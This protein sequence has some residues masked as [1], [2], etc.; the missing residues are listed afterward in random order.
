[1]INITGKYTEANIMIDQV[2]SGVIRQVQNLCNHPLFEDKQI[3]VMPD[4]HV[5]KSTVVGL[6]CY[7]E[8]ETL[9][10]SLLGSDIG[11]GML[12]IKLKKCATLNDYAKLDKVIR[13]HIPLGAEHRKTPSKYLSPKVEQHLRSH[14]WEEKGSKYFKDITSYINSVGTLGGGN[15]FISIEKGESGTYL[16]V[17]TGSRN[18]GQDVC[19]HYSSLALEQNP[20]AHSGELKQLSWLDKATSIKYYYAVGIGLL[21]AENNR[22]AIAQTIMKEMGWK[23]DLKEF[24]PLDI[25]HNY[26]EATSYKGEKLLH[27]RKGAIRLHQ[28]EYGLIPLNMADGSLLVKG[29]SSINEWNNSAPHGAGRLLKRSECC[30]LSM[31]EYKQRMNGI[32][33]TSVNV[34]TLDESPMAYKDHSKIIKAIEP[35]C[36]VVDH[37]KPVYNIKA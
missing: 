25:P 6:S 28:N 12:I 35:I 32:Y 20:Y 34:H 14:L 24:E 5:G 17:H 15:H 33:S 8:A 18:F 21:L 22:R 3:A 26:L 19:N 4:T 30:L 11:C 9:I 10:P 2:E 1:M 7:L 13:Q 37:L 29:N 36:E 27:I 16:I 31:D 23:E